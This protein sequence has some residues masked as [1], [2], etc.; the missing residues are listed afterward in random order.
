M[1]DLSEVMG[2]V[3]D[4]VVRA[5]IWDTAGQERFRQLT[6]TYYAGADGAIVVFDLS[7]SSEVLDAFWDG[8][9]F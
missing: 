5:H 8:M 6:S 1:Q 4:G 7:R 2:Q 3:G 9:G